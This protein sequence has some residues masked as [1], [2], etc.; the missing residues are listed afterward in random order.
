MG[1]AGV[2]VAL[3][4]ALPWAAAEAET[5][6]PPEAPAAVS[7][8]AGQGAAAEPQPTAEEKAD[9]EIGKSAA[10]E[11]EK[12]Y[13]VIEDPADLARISTII[14]RLRP[15]TEK[16][17]QLYM[18]KIVA[19]KDPKAGLEINA[20]SLPG[21]Y[22][23]YTRDLLGAVESEDELAAVTAH[24]MAHVCLNHARKLMGKD[25]R[26]SKVLTPIVLVSILTQS[27][28][29][30]PA[31]VAVVG[32]L[33]VQDALNSYGREAEAEADQA[34]VRYLYGSRQYNPVAMLTVVEGLAR[35]EGRKAPVELGVYQTHPDP[36]ERVASVTQALQALK[37]PVERRRVTKGLAA[38]AG[39][40]VKEGKEI[41]ELRLSV[42]GAEAPRVIF[43]PAAEWQ[44]LSPVARAQQS[45]GAMNAMLLSD[46]QLMEVSSMVADGEGTVQARGTVVL[47]VTAAD[48]E[49]HKSDVA[50]LTG[51]AM[52]AIRLAF[53][54]ERLKRA[55]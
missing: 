16:P 43:Q 50:A 9:A 15:L 55:Y 23:Y 8:P 3:A 1:V 14:E 27:K 4:F 11:V 33:V 53:E 35:I 7:P 29:V 42:G 13:Q 2:L 5:P 25:E 51:E 52:R 41:G 48:A 28:S 18:A 47:T 31:A 40:V 24:E 20:F 54:D 30:D 32:S 45:A 39:P 19:P 12:A 37:V 10:A 38:S 49:F 34:A 17:K 22:L 6:G 21:G 46:L 44:G 36:A 26:Y